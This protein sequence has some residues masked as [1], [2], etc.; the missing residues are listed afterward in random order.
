MTRMYDIRPPP[1]YACLLPQ[2]AAPWTFADAQNSE[3][4]TLYRSMIYLRTSIEATPI[5]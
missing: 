3:P 4:S 2:R 1:Q 5:R